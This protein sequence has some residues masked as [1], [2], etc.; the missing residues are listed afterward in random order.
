MVLIFARVK[1]APVVGV[2]VAL[3]KAGALVTVVKLAELELDAKAIDGDCG[4]VVE[5]NPVVSAATFV[6]A[7]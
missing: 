3:P 6:V 1:E 2:V 5:V 7:I 4:I